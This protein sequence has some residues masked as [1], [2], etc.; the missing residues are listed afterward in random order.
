M[1]SSIPPITAPRPEVP[2]PA[3]IEIPRLGVRSS[4]V[5]LGLNPDGTVQVPD[6]HHPEQAGYYCLT[7]T[8]QPP[9]T[10]GVVPGDVGPAAIYGHVD[11]DYKPGVFNRLHELAVGDEIRIVALDGS[12]RVFRVYRVEEFSKTTFPTSRVYGN[13]TRP[14][15]RVITCGG[16]WDQNKRSYRNQI[17][18][19]AA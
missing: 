9:C 6:V 12:V 13:T 5:T 4:L 7:S 14:E 17:L 16:P 2:S 15:L 8:G 10:A 18:V 1:V 11:G 19:L 3:A